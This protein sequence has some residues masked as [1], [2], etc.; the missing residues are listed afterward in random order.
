[1]QGAKPF[2]I[3]FVTDPSLSREKTQIALRA[4][5]ALRNHA[6]V[7]YY[8]GN[9][10]E[11]DL[12]ERVS[13]ETI[14]LLLL[15]WHMYLK[16]QKL[17]AHF[18]L[19]RMHGPTMVGWFAEDI[20]PHEVQEEDH[21]FRAILIDLNR[22]T[23]NE[24]A[25]MLKALLRDSTRWGLRPLLLPS[26][27]LHYE[28]WSAQV[29]LGF[30]IDT[31]LGL[32]E[33]ASSHWMKRANSIRVLVSAMWSLIFDNGPGKADRTRSNAERM[34]RAYFEIGVD[35]HALGLRLCY[36]EPGWKVKDVLHQ[37]WPGAL[38]P[39]TAGQIMIQ[40]SDMLRVHV[41]PENNE[42]E[43]VAMLY[44]SAPAER[45]GELMR[46]LWIEP[47][48]SLTRMERFSESSE[49]QEPYHKVLVT[50][51]D[52]ISNAAE[53]MDQMKKELDEKS[54][55]VVDLKAK[56]GTKEHIFVY[57]SG[58]DGEQL[59]DL[60]NRR[61]NETKSK[62]KSLNQQ[63]QSMRKDSKEDIREAS[64]L[65]QEIRELTA[66]QRSWITR[67]GEMADKFSN[68]LDPNAAP[69][70]DASPFAA[71]KAKTAEAPAPE[72]KTPEEEQEA[73]LAVAGTKNRDEKDKKKPFIRQ[74]YRK[75][76]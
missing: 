38:T 53:K 25:L 30:R 16:C 49:T 40:Y 31:V 58:L 41:D 76:S 12:I 66:Q 65:L 4:I 45:A 47:L 6:D 11:A 15:P 42:L 18:G 75:A 39:S 54:A 24:S 26:T 1:M 61:V 60:I 70:A 62:I 27:H 7:R 29:G 43:I 22:L 33:I 20:T 56:G 3:G 63:V 37:F 36:V 9:L 2:T 44:P 69:E 32:N 73:A 17:E 48:T 35:S 28:T 71:A 34:A 55:E 50:H 59:L 68:L 8:P 64:R 5:N 13:R 51:H 46:T 72:P 52:I 10:S 23:H 57:P 14:D 19:T 74:R 21:H 67:L